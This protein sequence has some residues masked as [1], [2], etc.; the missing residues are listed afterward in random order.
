MR[1]Y[2]KVFNLGSRKF[3]ILKYRKYKK[4]FRVAIFRKKYKKFFSRKNFEVGV[5]KYKKRF[6]LRTRKFHFTKYKKKSF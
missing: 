3:P 2:K 5:V 4:F 6:N 1:K